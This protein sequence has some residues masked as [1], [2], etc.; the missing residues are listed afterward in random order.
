MIFAAYTK[1]NWNMALKTAA[2]FVTAVISIQPGNVH[3]G[4]QRF[5]TPE[6]V[7]N[8]I[9]NLPTPNFGAFQD[10]FQRP[11]FYSARIHEA[12]LKK[13][14]C[15]QKT[16]GMNNL[17]FDFIVPGQD[18][19]IDRF[20]IVLLSEQG[21]DATANVHFENMGRTY[22]IRYSLVRTGGRWLIDDVSYD[23]RTL[24]EALSSPCEKP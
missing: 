11:D 3:A 18:Y 1:R 17:D 9:Y 24:F 5:E 15:Y 21:D 10:K 2:V 12:A 22:D 23:G 13:E 14:A 4:S 19:K 20:D 6:A 16:W 8:T 7:L